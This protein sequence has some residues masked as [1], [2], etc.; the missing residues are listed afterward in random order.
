MKYQIAKRW[1]DGII[2]LPALIVMSPF[3]GLILIFLRI[4]TQESPVFVQPRVGYQERVFQLYKIKTMYL[5][6]AYARVS[7]LKSLCWWLRQYSLDEV[8]Q[9][10]NVLKGDMS[11]VGPRPLLVE[12][13]PLY[14]EEQ[15]KR[16]TVK[17]GISGWAQLK[18]RNLLPWP[19]R[20]ALDIWYVKNQSL[21]LDLKILLCTV[22]HL[23]RPEGVRPEGLS[24]SEKF[25]GNNT[26]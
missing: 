9:F 25:S 12:Y 1:F 16:H 22:L 5:P 17:P 18:G 20:F 26:N 23:L 24:A 6:D 4:L 13:L 15:K 21:R 3:I 7:W 11:L 19:Q 14:S 8:L 2:A 10:W